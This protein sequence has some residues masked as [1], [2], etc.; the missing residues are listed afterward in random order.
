MAWAPSSSR[1]QV[2]PGRGLRAS[3]TATS[4]TS[5]RSVR[6]NQAILVEALAMLQARHPGVGLSW[7][8]SP[9]RD[10]PITSDGS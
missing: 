7:L 6:K 8:A 9:T 4:C 10:S 5:G 3:P 2:D 1:W